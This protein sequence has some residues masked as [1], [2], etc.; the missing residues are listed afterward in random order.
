M[1]QGDDNDAAGGILFSQ[2]GVSVTRMRPTKMLSDAGGM[3]LEISRGMG[4]QKVQERILRRRYPSLIL[5]SPHYS[6][7]KQNL[8]LVLPKQAA[9]LISILSLTCVCLVQDLEGKLMKES[10]DGS[11]TLEYP[12]VSKKKQGEISATVLQYGFAVQVIREVSSNEMGTIAMISISNDPRL[13]TNND[14]NKIFRR[15]LKAHRLPVLGHAK[16]S[17]PFRGESLCMGLTTLTAQ[18]KDGRTICNESLDIPPHFHALMDREE[19]FATANNESNLQLPPAYQT[20]AASFDGLTFC[21]DSHVM[22]P[23]KGSETVVALA[24]RLYRQTIRDGINHLRILDL[25]TGSGCLLLAMLRR[26]PTARGV[27]VDCCAAAVDVAKRN[28]ARCLDAAVDQQRCE[29]YV[30]TFAAPPKWIGRFDLIVSNPPY[31]IQ[32][33]RYQ[34]NWASVKY[35]PH[36]ALFVP[37]N[38]PIQHYRDIIISSLPVLANDQCVVAMEIFRDNAKA[39]ADLW[40][41]SGVLT[42]ISIGRDTKNCIR[43]IQGVYRRASGAG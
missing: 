2:G 3:V 24:E 42:Q 14:L 28:G 21:V 18:L 29:W 34:L 26:F 15:V 13:F 1:E 20:D 8:V 25:G 40:M 9:A 33:G 38:D 6:A 4:P 7:Y 16:L 5:A 39:V 31:H 43:S 37:K 32:G 23:R 41:Q 36:G 17:L 35:E 10:N 27:G 19:R 12:V 30:G 22:V 11:L